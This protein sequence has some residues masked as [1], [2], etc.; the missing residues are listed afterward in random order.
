MN[1]PAPFGGHSRISWWLSCL[2]VCLFTV[3]LA[4]QDDACPAM[5]RSAFAN[6]SS[7]CVDQAPVSLCHGNPT[8]SIMPLAGSG[9]GVSS[10]RVRQPGDMVPASGFDWFSTSR[11]DRTWGATRVFFPAYASDGLEART[12]AMLMFGDVALFLPPPAPIP[13]PLLDVAVAAIQGANLRAEP[14]TDARIIKSIAHRTRVKA[15]RRSDDGEWLEVYADPI[16]TGWISLSVLTGDVGAIQFTAPEHAGA[17][18]WFP[19]QTFDFQTGIDDA[20]CPGVAD[21][22]ILL[23]A[24]R[25]QTPRQFWLNGV[26]LRLTGTV[27]LQAQYDAGM[28]IYLLDG[29]VS[30]SSETGDVLVKSGFYTRATLERDLDGSAVVT[31]E[32]TVPEPYDYQ[33]MLVLPIDALHYPTRVG[34]DAYTIVERRPSDGDSPLQGIPEEATCKITA[35]TFGANM[36]SRPGPDA[37]VIAVMGHRESADPIARAIGRDSLPWWKLADNVWIRIDATVTGGK[38][39]A[40]PLIALES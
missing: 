40:V 36:R 5:Q 1:A 34:L 8:V 31:G 23:Q 3:V 19:W 9:G 10:V 39:S 27:F 20:P 7:L 21:S 17:P 30:I 32:W 22:G 4:A 18:L 16:Q 37:P 35:G 11:E 26:H 28:W 33:A 24:P 6:I 25:F 29:E 38:C 12:V 13:S 2:T 15:I 14:S